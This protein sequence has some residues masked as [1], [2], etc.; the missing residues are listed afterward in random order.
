MNG[1]VVL[2]FSRG[3][4]TLRI[5]AECLPLSSTGSDRVAGRRARRVREVDEGLVWD[6]TDD[7]STGRERAGCCRRTDGQCRISRYLY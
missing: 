7:D 4:Q 5:I 3:R 2:D 1:I 6:V